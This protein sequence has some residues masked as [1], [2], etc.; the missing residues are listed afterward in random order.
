MQEGDS[1][2]DAY[3]VF[4][5]EQRDLEIEEFARENSISSDYLKQL[6]TE[7]SFS[8]ILDNAKIKQE[9]RGSLGLKQLRELVTKVMQFV[10]EN[11][12]KYQ[13]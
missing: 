2:L 13:I 8:G 12:D 9:L 5:D 4:E 10:I 6:I 7:Y 1:V 3:A 11:C